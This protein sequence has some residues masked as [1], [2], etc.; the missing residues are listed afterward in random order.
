MSFFDLEQ[1]CKDNSIPVPQGIDNQEDLLAH[2]LAEF[3]V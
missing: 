3:G 1:L 2:L